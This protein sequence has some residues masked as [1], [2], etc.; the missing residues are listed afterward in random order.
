MRKD[1]GKPGTEKHVIEPGT[2][3]GRLTV[4]GIN[5][6]ESGF[7]TSRSGNRRYVRKYDCKCDCGNETTIAKEFLTRRKG[8]TRSCGCALKGAAR[9]DLT[10]RVFNNLEVIRL[11][12]SKDGGCGKHA[13]WICRCV[14]CGNERSFRSSDLI[15]GHAKDCGCGK[16]ARLSNAV[17]KDL[18]DM[19]FGHLHVVERDLSV[20][21][22]SGQ[23]ARWLCR[24]EI[25]GSIESVSGQMLTKY[26][27]DRCAK[28]NGGMSLGEVRIA[29]IFNSHGVKYDHDR[30]VG[31]INPKTG[32]QLLFDFVV[33]NY[34][35]LNR[36][37]VEFDGCQHF[38]TAP[39]AWEKTL[40][41]E[42]RIKYDEYKNQWC[43][44]NNI[45]LIRIPYT[46]LN[47]LCFNDL[48]PSKTAFLV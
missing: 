31:C 5:E 28:C 3:F 11:D 4:L 2:R 20:G 7:Y 22:A 8:G 33:E 1:C 26:G 27:K 9:K 36:F 17:L 21:H 46:H 34:D 44:E 38:R 19:T 40:P 43:S 39:E 47:K 41:L 29:E 48:L 16:S 35:G 14:I 24:C 32:R 45:P 12:D 42:E 18:S 37:I 23:H 25:C 13:Y 30:S 10:G 6:E 15:D